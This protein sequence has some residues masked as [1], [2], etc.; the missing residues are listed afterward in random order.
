MRKHYLGESVKFLYSLAQGRHPNCRQFLSF[1]H[2][3]SLTEAMCFAQQEHFDV[4]VSP[5]FSF[6]FPSAS[7]CCPQKQYWGGFFPPGAFCLL[8]VVTSGAVV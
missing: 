7:P 4:A 2:P 5:P 1:Q 8:P 6:L 3:P